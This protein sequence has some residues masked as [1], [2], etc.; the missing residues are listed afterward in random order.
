MFNKFYLAT[1]MLPIVF[2]NCA[3]FR[4]MSSKESYGKRQYESKLE[5]WIGSDVSSLI[6]SWGPPSGT[7]DLPN[8]EKMYTWGSSSQTSYTSYN[9]SM[10]MA[11]TNYG[12]RWCEQTFTVGQL[13]TIQKVIYKGND[14][15]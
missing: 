11:A 6:Q 8:G 10:N 7:F 3:M 12:S 1:I 13:G 4:Q 5:S 9:P 15:Y 14:C 2:S